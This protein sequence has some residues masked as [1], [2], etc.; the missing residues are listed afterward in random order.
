MAPMKSAGKEK[1]GGVAGDEAETHG[2]R[3]SKCTD[4]HQF[5]LVEE[6]LQPQEVIHWRKS[7]RESFPHE[8]E[9]ESVVFQSHVLRGLG[10]PISDFFRGFPMFIIGGFKCIT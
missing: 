8:R 2:W 10:F 1:A 4:F 5:G 3:S 7:D 9:N 6:H